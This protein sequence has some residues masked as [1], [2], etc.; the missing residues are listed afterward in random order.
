MNPAMSWTSAGPWSARDR[1][2]V[3]RWLATGAALIVA[4]WYFAAGAVE[5]ADQ[6][7]F[8]SLGV[9]GG[10]VWLVGLCTWLARGRRQVGRR[11]RL[12]L[13]VAPSADVVAVSADDLVAADGRR[14]FHRADCLLARTRNW[15]TAPRS[16]H[17][18]AGRQACP[19]CNP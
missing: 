10:L 14:W 5:P 2:A 11:A 1:R 18:R 9:A 15:P 17:E 13:G 8:V 19:A 16:E 7:R 6:L 12:L 3:T 4:A